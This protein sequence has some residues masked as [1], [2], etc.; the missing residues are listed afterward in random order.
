MA[1]EASRERGLNAP[2]TPLPVRG[3]APRPTLSLTGRGCEQPPARQEE[4]LMLY[5]TAAVCVLLLVYLL[6]ALLRPEWF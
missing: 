2:P 6:A 3:E 4:P 5:V 1:S